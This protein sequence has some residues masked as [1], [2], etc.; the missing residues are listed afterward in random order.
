MGKILQKYNEMTQI[1]KLRIHSEK[2]DIK[3][4]SSKINQVEYTRCI[5]E[6]FKE[7]TK[8]LLSHHQIAAFH[9]DVSNLKKMKG[10]MSE[11]ENA[12]M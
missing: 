1:Y 7:L 6:I 11:D 3:M 4:L 10:M 12:T 8:Y 2:V 5:Q 9:N